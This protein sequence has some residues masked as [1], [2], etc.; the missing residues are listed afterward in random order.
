[1]KK[2]ALVIT[3]VIGVLLV[4]GS[5]GSLDANTIGFGQFLLQTIIGIGLVWCG[6]AFIEIA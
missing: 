1:M 3:V 2:I 6:L 4:L 5:V